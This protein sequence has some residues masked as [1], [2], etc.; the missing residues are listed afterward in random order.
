MKSDYI[1]PH[2]SPFKDPLPIQFLKLAPEST[3][4][5]FFKLKDGVITAKQKLLLFKVILLDRGI[6]AKTNVGYGQFSE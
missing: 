3:L 2:K 5:F 1:T 6:G 4:K